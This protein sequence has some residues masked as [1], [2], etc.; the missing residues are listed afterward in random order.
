M[1]RPRIKLVA[2]LAL[3]GLAAVGCQK[4]TITVEPQTGVEVSGTVYTV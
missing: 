3:L 1:N 4:E 2:V